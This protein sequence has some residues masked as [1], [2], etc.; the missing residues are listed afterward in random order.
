MQVKKFAVLV[1]G[2]GTDLQAIIDG[3]KTGIIKNGEISLVLGSKEDIFALN[4]AQ[5]ENIK[6][7]V[8]K[9]K[10]FSDL[11]EFDTKILETLK[12]HNADF[13]VLA[14]Y[15]NIIGKQ[16]ISAYE[17][18]IINIHPALIPSFCG[19]GYYGSKV[20]EAVYKSGVRVSGCTVHFVD[21]GADT[22][23]II[24][25]KTVEV[26]FEDTPETIAKKVLKEEH[27]LL[28]EIVGK[29]AED[30]IKIIDNRVFIEE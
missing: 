21:E 24:A 5:K 20:H 16:T 7:A 11:A 10:D 25:Q 3:I 6:T 13:V 9:R 26:L 19:M 18:K 12:A 23:L 8:V 30:K 15:L 1:S 28:P 14:G 4:R 29:M 17:N 2:G 22:G 27:K